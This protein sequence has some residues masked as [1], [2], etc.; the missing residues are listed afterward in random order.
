M[1]IRVDTNA[2]K[3]TVMFPT[4]LTTALYNYL[5]CES[6]DPE[7]GER[8]RL[9]LEKDLEAPYPASEEPFMSAVRDIVHAVEVSDRCAEMGS[10]FDESVVRLEEAVRDFLAQVRSAASERG[11]A[12][13]GPQDNTVL[14][15]IDDD[16]QAEHAVHVACDF[17]RRAGGSVVVLH[18]LQPLF[19]LG[20]DPLV[21]Q[22]RHAARRREAVGLLARAQRWLPP[23]M[24]AQ[25]M[26]R[27][28][29]PSAQIV[30]GAKSVN[31]KL[32]V[33]GTP[34]Q[35]RLARFLLGSTNEAVARDAECPVVTVGHD[36]PAGTIAEVRTPPTH[37]LAA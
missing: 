32:I 31:A 19:R 15:A 27:E 16:E 18:V 9:A 11:V 2:A 21:A 12:V 10:G 3:E 24:P 26:L 17:A 29:V 28:G 20:R 34:C 23:G 22:R 6:D 30:A 7:R 1:I 5:G 35:A 8:V 14:V 33:I 13:A 4:T 36:R 25:R 37:L